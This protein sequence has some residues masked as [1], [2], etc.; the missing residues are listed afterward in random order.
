MRPTKGAKADKRRAKKKRAV[1]KQKAKIRKPR[2]VNGKKATKKKAANKKKTR[3]VRSTKA[4]APR[5]GKV[6]PNPVPA[7]N[8]MGIGAESAA[9]DFETLPSDESAPIDPDV[10]I[11]AEVEDDY[12]DPGKDD[13][14]YF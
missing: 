9:P 5:K 11:A 7:D 4:D 8:D 2:S 13:E 10:E 12:F 6:G 3:R 14:G 1:K